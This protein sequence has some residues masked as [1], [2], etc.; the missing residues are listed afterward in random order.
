ARI[1]YW[2]L[3]EIKGLVKAGHVRFE[4]STAPVAITPDGVTLTR[5]EGSGMAAGPS[6]EV[7]ADDILLL[8]GYEM[9]GA[10]LERAGVQLAGPQ[11]A[12]TFNLRTMETNVPGL[13]V[14]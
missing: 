6:F 4:P 13:Y 2:L 12:P 9:D 5:L 3:P 8:T 1:K 7:P 10:L 14:A 11:R